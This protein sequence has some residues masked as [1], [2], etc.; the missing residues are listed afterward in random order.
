MF[1]VKHDRL[2]CR[3]ISVGYYWTIHADGSAEFRWSGKKSDW[4]KV[5]ESFTD[6]DIRWLWRNTFEGYRPAELHDRIEWIHHE[7]RRVYL[8]QKGM[9]EAGKEA[10][11]RAQ[12]DVWNEQRRAD[13]LRR[14]RNGSG[15]DIRVE[16]GGWHAG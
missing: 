5:L 15:D 11:V 14:N 9:E 12:G 16:F 7:Q 6:E 2:S 3:E 13:Y 10:A 4:F 1:H 8:A